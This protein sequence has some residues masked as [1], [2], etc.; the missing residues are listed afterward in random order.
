MSNNLSDHN[1]ESSAETGQ[2]SRLPE[3]PDRAL[4]RR[5]AG[6]SAPELGAFYDRWSDRV[7][8]LIVR[9]IKDPDDAELVVEDTFWC[10][11]QT[12][13]EYDAT[14]G[15]VHDWLLNIVRRKTV[16]YLRSQPRRTDGLDA[17]IAA[18]KVS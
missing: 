15:S 17:S 10:A 3:Q 12:A 9:V 4:V 14:S 5:L 11:W 8:S 1:I 7:Y 18:Q 2:Q 6:G 13:S 16:E